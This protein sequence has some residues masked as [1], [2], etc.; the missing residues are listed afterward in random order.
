[1][2]THKHIHTLFYLEKYFSYQIAAYLAT[3]KPVTIGAHCVDFVTNYWTQ[4]ILMHLGYSVDDYIHLF[5]SVVVV[6]AYHY[7]YYLSL[8]LPPPSNDGHVKLIA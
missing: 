2:H 4:S 6:I 3:H 5:L 8:L 7:L 1:M